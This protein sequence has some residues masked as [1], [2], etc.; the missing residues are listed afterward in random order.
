MYTYIYLLIL[1]SISIYMNCTFLAEIASE[2]VG[3]RASSIT[4][5]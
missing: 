1:L 2:Q 5:Y 4:Y 3:R